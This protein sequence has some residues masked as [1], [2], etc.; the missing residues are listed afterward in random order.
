MMKESLIE[1][2][3]RENGF[4]ESDEKFSLSDDCF[5]G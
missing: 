5:S 1:L 2:R 3:R 4:G